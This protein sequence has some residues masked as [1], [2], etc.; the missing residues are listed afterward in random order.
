[1]TETSEK[2][3]NIRSSIKNTK[4]IKELTYCPIDSLLKFSFKLNKLN[5]LKTSRQQQPKRYKKTHTKK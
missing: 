4:F 1:M 3:K 2:I 5:N